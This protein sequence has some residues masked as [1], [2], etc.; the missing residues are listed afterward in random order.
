[1]RGVAI[2]ARNKVQ[3]QKGLSFAAF[4]RLCAS[5]DQCHAALAKWRW[6]DGFACPDCGE[7]RYSY[8]A[9]RRLY[10]CSACSLQTSARAGT[11]FWSCPGFVDG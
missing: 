9:M 4:H 8:I 1:M 5:E 6:P 2:M 10:Q 3:F 11:I 7:R